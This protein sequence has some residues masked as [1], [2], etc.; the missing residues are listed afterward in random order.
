MSNPNV[1]G[2]IDAFWFSWTRRESRKIWWALEAWAY[3]MMLR[4]GLHPKV[5]GWIRGNAYKSDAR[6]RSARH[7]KAMREI[8]RR[9]AGMIGEK[10][11]AAENA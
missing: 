10:E 7:A 5:W 8:D 3:M 9:Y 6:A 2:P 1:R 4:H 11:K